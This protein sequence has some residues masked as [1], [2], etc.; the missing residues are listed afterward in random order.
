M[1]YCSAFCC[2]AYVPRRKTEVTCFK[3]S[4]KEGKSCQTQ[5]CSAII[6]TLVDEECR[7]VSKCDTQGP[8]VIGVRKGEN[9]GAEEEKNPTKINLGQA[10]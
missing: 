10:T 6:Q 9:G 8:G 7:Q 1:P 3:K 5:V 4:K 2:V